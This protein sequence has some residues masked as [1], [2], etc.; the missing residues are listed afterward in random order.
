M[1][2][3]NWSER[4]GTGVG[5]LDRGAPPVPSPEVQAAIALL[6]AHGYTV[7][8]SHRPKVSA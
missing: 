5:P 8:A 4:Q 6:E 2:T 7:V 1:A 3:V